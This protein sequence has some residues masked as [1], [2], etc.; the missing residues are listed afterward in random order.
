MTVGSGIKPDLLTLPGVNL[1]RR[2]RA[3]AI[4][5]LND[6]FTAGEEFHLALRTLLKTMLER[7]DGNENRRQVSVAKA[8]F[9]FKQESRIWLYQ[10]VGAAATSGGREVRVVGDPGD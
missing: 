10:S 2:S 3:L 1:D 8:L 5:D 7:L 6:Q 4:A 9:S